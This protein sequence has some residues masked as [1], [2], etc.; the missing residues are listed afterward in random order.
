MTHIGTAL[1]RHNNPFMWF[2]L[3]FAL[4][5]IFTPTSLWIKDSYIRV[6]NTIQGDP[7]KIEY[8]GSV[9]HNFVGNYG[10]IV[11]DATSRGIVCEASG[12]PF[13]YDVDGTRPD[14]LLM[15]WWAV[16]DPRCYGSNLPIGVYTMSTCWSIYPIMGEWV[17][18]L[19]KKH[20]IHTEEPFQ[21]Y[22][23]D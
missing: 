21:I 20:C 16:S 1:S 22:P 12:G 14:P 3:T 6:H 15:S 11:R 18:P 19:A 4:T 23:R 5:A 13:P 7:I 8:D 2:F 9:V 17:S 10:V